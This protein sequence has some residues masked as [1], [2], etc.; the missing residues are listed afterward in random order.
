[1]DGELDVGPDRQ[2]TR[3]PL[4]DTDRQIVVARLLRPAGTADS[5]DRH[6]HRGACDDRGRRRR[7][8]SALVLVVPW[9][10]ARTTGAHSALLAMRWLHAPRPRCR[11]RSARSVRTGTRA[12]RSARSRGSP[13]CVTAGPMAGD[14]FGDGA[15]EPAAHRMLLDRDDRAGLGRGLDRLLVERGDRGHVDDAGAHASGGESDRRLRARAMTMTPLAMMATSS[16]SRRVSALPIS[17]LACRRRRQV[18]NAAYR[19]MRRNT[20]PSCAAAA[21]TAC[22]VSQGSDG[23][24]IVRLGRSRSQAKSSIE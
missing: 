22:A 8:G 23:A 20:G 15:A 2:S 18:R 13:G 4:P 12:S 24:T 11:W 3:Q 14:H 19:L 5:I 10:M 17:K 21:S 7:S 6:R 1:M 16:P 9:S